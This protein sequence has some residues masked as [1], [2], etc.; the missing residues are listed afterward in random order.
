MCFRTFMKISK[1]G[2]HFQVVVLF[3]DTNKRIQLFLK[4]S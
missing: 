1:F 4:K 2:W 3:R